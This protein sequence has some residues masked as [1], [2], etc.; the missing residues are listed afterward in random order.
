MTRLILYLVCIV[1]KAETKI[2]GL[3]NPKGIVTVKDK[4]AIVESN[5]LAMYNSSWEKVTTSS[6]LSEY[7][8]ISSGPDDTVLVANYFENQVTFP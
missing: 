1:G 8:E 4:L 7:I 5:K 3:S 6:S 2:T